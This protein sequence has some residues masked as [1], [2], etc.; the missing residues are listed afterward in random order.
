VAGS[1]PQKRI[2]RR[3]AT[4]LTSNIAGADQ[5]LESKG[6][7]YQL[8]ARMTEVVKLKEVGGRRTW[9]EEGAGSKVMASLL[10]EAAA[11]MGIRKGSMRVRGQGVT[12][13]L[14]MEME[15]GVAAGADMG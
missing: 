5:G 15:N 2:G 14:H 10:W 13:G 8:P 4:V 6:G 3:A 11:L 1:T 9:S 7:G 12:K